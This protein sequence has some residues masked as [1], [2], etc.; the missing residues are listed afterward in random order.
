MQPSAPEAPAALSYREVDCSYAARAGLRQ[1]H[2]VLRGVSFRVQ[3]HEFVTVIGPTAM[4]AD[5]AATAVFVM[6]IEEGIRFLERLELD[7]LLI[8]PALDR[9]A[10]KGMAREYRCS[11]S[12][13]L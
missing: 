12:A 10:T 2:S 11:T 4:L 13:I 9:Y 1:R 7:G 5:A 6:G 8:T 3:P